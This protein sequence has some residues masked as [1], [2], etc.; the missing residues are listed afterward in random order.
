MKKTKHFE[1]RARQ[2]G[3]HEA[4][5]VFILTYGTRVHAAEAVF[6][7]LRDKDIPQEDRSHRGRLAG[8]VIVL[9]RDGSLMTCY[10]RRDSMRHIRRKCA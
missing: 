2:R 6:C 5:T 7:V 8:R 4:D 1:T 3:Q 9:S 10:R